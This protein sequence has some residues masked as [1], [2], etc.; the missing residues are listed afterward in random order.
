MLV[1]VVIMALSVHFVQARRGRKHLTFDL[2]S[3]GA[4]NIDD[5]WRSLEKKV[6]LSRSAEYSSQ[7]AFT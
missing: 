4:W 3:N 1:A 2:E 5:T 6:I 7:P